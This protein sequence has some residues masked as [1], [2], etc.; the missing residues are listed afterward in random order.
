MA[1]SSSSHS[2][3]DTYAPHTTR[4]AS[5]GT[6]T[7]ARARGAGSAGRGGGDGRR[8]GGGWRLCLARARR[9]PLDIKQSAFARW[10]PSVSGRVAWSRLPPLPRWPVRA[11]QRGVLVRRPDLY[12][13]LGLCSLQLKHG[14]QP[15]RGLGIKERGV[16]LTGDDEARMSLSVW[17]GVYQRGIAEDASD[18]GHETS[19]TARVV[20]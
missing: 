18:L 8:A 5:S 17:F 1:S 3:S 15:K 10:G 20:T 19:V 6:P 14:L 13:S 2:P 9:V 11:V 12:F 7:P 4:P 16:W